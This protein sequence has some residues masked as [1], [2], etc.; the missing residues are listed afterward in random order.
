MITTDRS[1]MGATYMVVAVCL[2][3]V[4]VKNMDRN[5]PF[6]DKIREYDTRRTVFMELNE[7]WLIAMGITKKCCQ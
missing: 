1:G 4:A 2:P 6:K 3:Y 5:D 7:D